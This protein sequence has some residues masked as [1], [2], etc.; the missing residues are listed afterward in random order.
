MSP[1]VRAG[2]G[3]PATFSE[4]AE[5]SD[6]AMRNAR[7]LARR[8]L[9]ALQ[10]G[11]P[12]APGFADVV[13]ELAGAVGVLTAQLGRDGDR[14]DAREPVLDVVPARRRAAGLGAR[15]VGDGDAGA[16]ALDRAGPAAGH[17]VVAVRGARRDAGLRSPGVRSGWQESHLPANRWRESG[18]PATP[19][20]ARYT[21][22]GA[23]RRVRPQCSAKATPAPTN[24]LNDAASEEPRNTSSIASTA[25]AAVADTAIRLTPFV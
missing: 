18:F 8:A 13:S 9:T 11:E 5:R 19:E 20:R 10:D 4:L 21:V 22:A 14:E 1:L 2:A 25:P 23:V 16:G 12:A 7:V 3:T 15:H 6:Y 24:Q 17:G